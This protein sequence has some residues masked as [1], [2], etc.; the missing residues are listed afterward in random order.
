MRWERLHEVL[1]QLRDETAHA[2]NRLDEAP[3]ASEE[4]YLAKRRA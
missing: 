1:I 4:E 2:I 3:P